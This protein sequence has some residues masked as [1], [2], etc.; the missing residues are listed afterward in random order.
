MGNAPCWLQS[1]HLWK[2]LLP[3]FFC[4]CLIFSIIVKFVLHTRGGLVSSLKWKIDMG[5]C[6]TQLV[7]SFRSKYLLCWF[8]ISIFVLIYLLQCERYLQF[9]HIIIKAQFLQKAA[10]VESVS[11]HPKMLEIPVAWLL[12]WPHHFPKLSSA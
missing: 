12:C 6:K 5:T 1:W 7:V 9:H 3:H 8:F 11:R 2:Y 10:K 4:F